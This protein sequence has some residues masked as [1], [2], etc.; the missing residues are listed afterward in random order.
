[1]KK[2]YY[3]AA[4]ILSLGMLASCNN[5]DTI[6]AGNENTQQG[7]AYM[8]LTIAGESSGNSRTLVP[9]QPGD[10]GEN[11]IEE[12][13]ILLCDASGV[14]SNV[15]ENSQ[16]TLTSNEDGTW[17]T[18]PISVSTGDYYVYVIA[19]PGSYT[20]AVGNN[21]TTEVI[22]NLT[23]TSI[24]GTD[25]YA[26]DNNFI[27]FNACNGKDDT[28][29]AL[30]RV[31]SAND[32]D[33]PAET[34]TI[35]LD[36]LVAKITY[37]VAEGEDFKYGDAKNQLT[38]LSTIT[39]DGF[40]LLNGITSTY[41][42]QHWSADSP[43]PTPSTQPEDGITNLLVT[44]SEP[45]PTFYR[46]WEYYSTVTNTGTDDD[47]NYTTV[48]DN[49]KAMTFNG[50]DQPL[51]CMENNSGAG[52]EDNYLQG[53]TTG[54]LFKATA[55]VTGCDEFKV[56]GETVK[57]FYGYRPA[58]YPVEYY[59]TLEAMQ[60]AHPAV[61]NGTALATVK[62]ELT[63][64]LTNNTVSDFRTK[65]MV[66]VYEGCVMYYTHYIEDQNYRTEGGDKYHA[67]MRN[68]IYSLIVNGVANIG[69]DVPGGWNPDRDP[70]KPITPNP[71]LNVI[72]Q[73]NNWVLSN[74][75]VTLQ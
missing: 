38:S 45:A 17:V 19:N 33:N 42:Q 22:G 13:I 72:C 43:N 66:Y 69:D 15:I 28:Q 49:T 16:F 50:K 55:N 14:I 62:E 18:N 75:N 4:S 70:E 34:S 2:F 47:P 67:V 25:G 30:V 3:I 51:F 41:L 32:Y 7:E 11:A 54:V 31:T 6:A 21:V 12:A 53:N 73:P 46:G 26:T 23:E 48:R 24:T 36:R 58:N 29:G 9:I 52:V 61:F 10:D 60:A 20:P 40:N 64:D 8:T 65:Y 35:M 56:N 27:M 74:Y 71:Y 63:E 59:A 57:C 68:T 44:P 39:I 37:D 5:E 1:M